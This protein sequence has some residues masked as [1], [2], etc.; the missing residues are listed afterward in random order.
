MSVGVHASAANAGPAS[1]STLT[2]AG[3]TTTTGSTVLI[4]AG[5]LTNT[6]GATPVQDS[7]SNTWTQVDTALTMAAGI[8]TRCYKAVNITGGAGHTF[9]VDSNVNSLMLLCAQEIKTVP[10]SP[11][12]LDGRQLDT[13]SPFDSPSIAPVNSTTIT[14]FVV[15]DAP[16]GTEVD[17]WGGSFASG[18][19][20]EEQGNANTGLTGSMACAT[21]APGT[22]NGSITVSGVTVTEAACWIVSVDDSSG[23]DTLMAQAVF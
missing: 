21:K 14:A 2:T 4:F 6:F 16:S 9:S 5:I 10:A 3:I 12:V 17:T 23:G 22:Y 13:S 19:K 18:D 15:T 1:V 7:K 8:E 11:T 20:T